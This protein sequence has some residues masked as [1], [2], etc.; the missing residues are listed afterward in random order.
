MTVKEIVIA[1]AAELGLC[2]RV[3]AYLDGSVDD[4]KEETEALVRCFNLV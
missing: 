4:G 3:Q 2:D 1:A